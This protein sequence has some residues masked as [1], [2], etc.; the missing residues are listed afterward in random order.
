MSYYGYRPS[1]FDVFVGMGDRI[2][3]LQQKRNLTAEDIK[4]AT[5]IE[6]RTLYSIKRNND[7]RFSNIVKLANYF[8]VSLDW[9]V[10]G[11]EHSNG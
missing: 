8:N 6:H 2:D 10:Y 1:R 4:E 11:K 5:G 7:C 3:W 9:L